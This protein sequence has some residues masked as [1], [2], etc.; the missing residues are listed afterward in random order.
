MLS[1]LRSSRLV[2]LLALVAWTGSVRANGITVRI[3]E[4]MS[5][6]GAGGTN[7]WFEITNYGTTAVDIAGWR[8]D[9]N[10]FTFGAS[11]A[12]VPYTLGPGPAW[13]LLGPGES[14][15]MLETSAPSTAVPAFQ[16]FWNLGDQ[17][18][19]VRNPKIA[20][21]TGSGVSLGSGGDGVVVFDAAGT[22]VTPRVNFGAATTGS[23]FYW[24]YDAAGQL[25][26]AAGGVVS[27]VGVA[28][29]YSTTG[30]ATNIGS[31]GI[32]VVAAPTVNRYWTANGTALGGSGSW[33]TAGTTWSATATPVTATTW[34]NGAL[35]VFDGTAGTIT[36]NAAVSPLGLSFVTG[37][38]TLAAGTGSIT[39]PSVDVAAGQ[40]ATI[41]ARLTGSTG[42]TLLGGGTLVLSGTAN[43]YTGATSVG[44]GILRAGA[45][46]VIPNGSRLAVARFA[47]ADLSGFSETVGGIS[48]LGTIRLGSSLTVNVAG[49]AELVLDGTLTGSGDLIIDSAGTGPQ[50]LDASTQTIADGAVKDY[51]GATLVRRGTLRVDYNGIPTRTNGVTVEGGGRLQLGSDAEGFEFTFGGNASLPINVNGG[52][53]GQAAGDDV[54]LRNPVNVTADSTFA[55]QNTVTPDPANPTTEELIL[56]GPLTGT[57]GRTITI[58]AS[59]TTPGADKGRVTFAS[60]SGNAFTGTVKPQVNAVARFAGNY[61]GVSVTLDQGTLDGS[62]SVGA[63]SGPGTIAPVADFGPTVLTATSITASATTGFLFEFNTANADPSWAS[64]TASGNSVLRLTDGTPLP[65][66]LGSGNAVQLFLNV[67]SLTAGDAFTGGFFTTADATASIAGGSYQ[68]YVYGDGFGTDITS[69]GVGWYSLASYNTRQGSALS[70]GISMV[71]TTAS[72][73]G[74]PTSGY[75]MRASYAPSSNLVIDVPSGSQTQA[76]VGYA[77]IAVA[78]SVTKTGAGT[79]VFDAANSYTGPTTVSAGTLQVANANAVASSAVTVASG[80][81]LAVAPGITMKAPSVTLNGGTLSGGTVAVNA[82][83]GIQALTINAGTIASTTALVVGPGGLVDLPDA[84]RVTL[85]VASLAVDQA[86]GGGK[87][88]LGAGQVRIAAGGFSA[89]NLRADIVAGFAGGSW[90]GTTGITSGTAAASGGTRAVGYVVEGDGSARVSFAAPGDTNLDGVVDLLDLL[91][92]LG[93]GTYEVPTPAVW[94]QGD[95]NYDGVT[96]LLDLLAILGSNTY[97]QGNYFPAAAGSLGGLAAPAAVPEP[98]AT[99]FLLVSAASIMLGLRRRR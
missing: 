74:S 4:V 25:A 12:L 42:V 10:S 58:T 46:E 51:T 24:S 78:D 81:T 90:N 77:A 3:T 18:G 91:E 1:R 44:A 82:A 7:D 61:A 22:E 5:S 53:L 68:T 19:N 98:G 97:D 27:T 83:T 64:P 35:A 50:R 65:T 11:V 73:D 79:V 66:A 38:S 34:A 8:M 86:S 31:P 36:V 33:T 26:T 43:D 20:T 69:N 37:A 49:A 99:G 60:G 70:A 94:A 80:A 45:S 23:T 48:G 56:A 57:A 21:Y 39:T 75:V 6:S 55:I 16:A 96:D 40:T 71:A 13:T 59:N 29:A 88:D 92:I 28:D 89:A 76:Q 52:T 14:A 84:S 32:A 72:F 85:G 93:S 30:S 2:A 15:V 63:V 17:P 47:Q 41:A 95:F 87:L 9:D 62:G 54:T 67:T